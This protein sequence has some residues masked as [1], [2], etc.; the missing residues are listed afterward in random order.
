MTVAG[1]PP[2]APALVTTQG[3]YQRVFDVYAPIGLAVLFLLV[4]NRRRATPTRTHE[5]NPVELSYSIFLTLIVV[6]LL[7]V[8]FSSMHQTDTVSLRAKPSVIVDVTGARWEWHFYYPA[9]N[10]NV[11][12]GTT[13][14]KTLVVPTNQ[15][16]R[17]RLSSVDVIHAFWIPAVKFK[18]DNTPGA[19]Q[20]IQL[21][22][23][24]AGLM[25]GEC[26]EFCG[27]R[28]ADMV[29]FVRAV[30][31][32]QFQRWARSGGKAALT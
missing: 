23:T 28:H 11:Y 20:D 3:Q 2:V 27:L 16:V 10:I 18:H 14:E 21:V 6:G 15:P 12:S 9:Y 25:Q 19:T 29:F 30:S 4:K 32:A 26:A 22:F 13:G 31:P 24:K 8:T 5:N 7:Y 17:F 1:L